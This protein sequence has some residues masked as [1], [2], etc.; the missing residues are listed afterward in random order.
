VQLQGLIPCRLVGMQVAP[1]R[2]NVVAWEAFENAGHVPG[3]FPGSD[4]VFAGSGRHHY[5]SAH[6]MGRA[7]LLRGVGF[8]LLHIQ[9][10]T[11][12][13]WQPASRTC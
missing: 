11:R 9:G 8:F 12:T 6:V 3:R 4:G 13:S 7:D 5:L 10:A 2:V 1:G